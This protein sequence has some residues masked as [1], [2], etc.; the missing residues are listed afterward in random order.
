MYSLILVRSHSNESPFRILL[1]LEV[2]EFCVE[3]TVHE[4]GVILEAN[5]TTTNSFHASRSA[6]VNS[7]CFLLWCGIN[8]LPAAVA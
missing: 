6:V 8:D 3:L 2:A 4:G 1:F 7:F 5:L